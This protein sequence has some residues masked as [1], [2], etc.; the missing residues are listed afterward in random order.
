MGREQTTSAAA[1][2][3]GAAIVLLLAAL[4]SGIGYE[5]IGRVRD[6]ERLPRIGRPINIGSRTLNLDCSGQGSPA[7]ILESDGSF[8]GYSWMLVQKRIAQFTRVCWYDRAGYGWS[9]PAPSPRDA[10]AIAHDLNALLTAAAIAPPYV[11]M[12]IGSSGFY[13]RVFAN[14]YRHAI[15]GMILVNPEHED[16]GRLM[17]WTRGPVPDFLKP[18]NSA[19]AQVAGQIGLSRLVEKRMAHKQRKPDYLTDNEWAT[20]NSLQHLSKT[21]PAHAKEMADLPGSAEEARSMGGIGDIPLTILASRFDDIPE[22]QRVRESLIQQL[23]ALSRRGKLV[24]VERVGFFLQFSAP[25]AIASAVREMV[26]F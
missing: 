10:R 22:H 6:R 15:A 24:W 21:F 25:E 9:D 26:G 5:R 18:A 23:A 1:V 3:A 4:A 16:E 20:I 8:P 11:L 17:P 14:L 2:V 13:V 19:F 7:V 12:A